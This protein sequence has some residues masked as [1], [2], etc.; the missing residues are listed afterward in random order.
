MK[1]VLLLFLVV[2]SVYTINTPFDYIKNKQDKMYRNLLPSDD[3][4]PNTVLPFLLLKYGTL[5][6]EVIKDSGLIQCR[7]NCRYFFLQTPE[8]IYSVYPILT[9]LM[10]LPF[11]LLPMVLNLIPEITSHGNI[12]RILLLGRTTAGIY[13]TFS[14]V[15]FYLMLQKVSTNKLRIMIFTLFYAFGT[16]T[17]SISSRGLWQHTTSQFLNSIALYLLFL[18][19]E[20]PKLIPWVAFTLGWAV[21]ARPTNLIFAIIATIYVFFNYRKYFITFILA[22][23][24]AIIFLCAINIILFG[25][26]FTEG[27]SARGYN[28]FD[29]T[30]WSTP[31]TESLPVFFL[32]PARSYLVLSPPLLF[33]FLTCFKVFFTRKYPTQFSKLLKYLIPIYLVN[34]LVILK[35]VGWDG[36]N[37]F[38]YRMFVDILPITALLAFDFLKDISKREFALLCVLIITSILFQINAVT[39]RKSRCLSSYNWGFYCL[40]PLKR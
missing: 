11:Y 2:F 26:P 37:A 30:H 18:S 17:W 39:L 15:L 14:V 7:T 38:G 19:V 4:I 6:Y 33:S 12:L 34:T 9:G 20:K 36:S 5:N 21:A 27:Y 3:V 23:L 10:A 35:W 16:C 25:S 1:T 29:L 31:F 40:L 8:G 24:P 32:S 22:T 28:A 13:A